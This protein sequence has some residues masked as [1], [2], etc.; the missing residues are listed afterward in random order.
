MFKNY[1]T[2]TTYGFISSFFTTTFPSKHFIIDP[3]TCMVRLSILSFK[4]KGTKI[5]LFDNMIKYNDP[6]IFQGSIRWTQG[7]HRNDLHNLYGPIVK[8]LEW[9]DVNNPKIYNIFNLSSKGLENLMLSYNNN[10][11][12]FHSLKYY[13]SIIDNIIEN[14]TNTVKNVTKEDDN[15]IYTDLKKL[16]NKNEINIINDILE[17]MKEKNSDEINSLINAIDAIIYIKEKKVKRI[18]E[19]NTRALI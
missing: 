4:P 9:Y 8:A 3:F 7:D 18:I 12:T 19:N 15:K 16:W 14:D 13:K 17:E 6:N 1:I 2:D 10:N 11:T 5:S